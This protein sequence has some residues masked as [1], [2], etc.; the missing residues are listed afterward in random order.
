M[1][2]S[3]YY[4]YKADILKESGNYYEAIKQDFKIDKRRY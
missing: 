3:E 4:L 2:K 1:T